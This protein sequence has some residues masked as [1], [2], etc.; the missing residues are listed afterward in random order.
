MNEFNPKWKIIQEISAC[1][2]VFR[3]LMQP[4]QHDVASS[5][6]WPAL[7][8]GQSTLDL[9]RLRSRSA[10]Y[11]SHIQSKVVRFVDPCFFSSSNILVFL[12]NEFAHMILEWIALV[13]LAEMATAFDLAVSRICIFFD[14]WL[15]VCLH[16]HPVLTCR[17]AREGNVA[18]WE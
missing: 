6:P 18:A 9:A 13:S 17:S 14:S 12:Q 10:L 15:C 3:H 4:W 11:V 1:L 8:R 16:W 2:A 5:N 7:I